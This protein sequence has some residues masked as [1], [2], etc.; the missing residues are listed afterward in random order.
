MIDRGR[1]KE[2]RPEIDTSV[3]ALSDQAERQEAARWLLKQP[4][5]LA[6]DDRDLFANIRRQQEELVKWFQ[7]WLGYRLVID[8]DFARLHKVAL[9]MADTSRPARRRSGAAF[10]QRRY[11]LLSLVLALFENGSEQVSLS[12]L[13]SEL[14]SLCQLEGLPAPSFEQRGERQAFVDVVRFLVSYGVLRFVDGDEE[15]YLAGTNDALYDVEQRIGANLISTGRQ[16]LAE[17]ED[18]AGDTGVYAENQDGSNLRLRHQLMRALCE[19]P[20]LYYEDLTAEQH[21]YVIPTRPA[22]RAEL[23]KMF[24]LRLEA[25]SDGLL[26]LD[27]DDGL[28]DIAFPAQSS[29]AHAALLLG[30]ALAMAAGDEGEDHNR[31]FSDQEL[32]LMLQSLVRNYGQYWKS[33]YRED[34]ERVWDFLDEIKPLLAAFGMIKLDEGGAR[35]RP[36]ASRYLAEPNKQANLEP[37]P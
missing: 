36:L 6:R 10:D 19:E 4:L 1:G 14:Q 12:R 37:V 28:T 24:G 34:R 13:A 17:C 2:R 29:V 32:F 20:V 25:R 15:G 30:F 23:A 11:M 9:P 27:S 33:E 22:L 31:F 26:P 18:P 3:R 35:V 8:R 21:A 16:P 5:V 7:Q